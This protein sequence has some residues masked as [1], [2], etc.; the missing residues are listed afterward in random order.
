M[1]YGQTVWRFVLQ[2]W[3]WIHGN[4]ILIVVLSYGFF[5]YSL[6]RRWRR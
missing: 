3:C 2:N 5:S 1:V 6:W 4:K